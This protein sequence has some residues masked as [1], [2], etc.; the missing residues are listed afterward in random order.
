M[1]NKLGTK[2]NFL[3]LIQAKYKK[4]IVNDCSLSSKVRNKTLQLLLFNIVLDILGKKMI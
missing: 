1:F 4:A 2:G 3:N